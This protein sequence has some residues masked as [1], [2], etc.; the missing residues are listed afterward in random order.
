MARIRAEG[1]P[2]LP[3]YRAEQDGE[4][5][6]WAALRPHEAAGRFRAGRGA[7]LAALARLTPAEL[8]R[9]GVHARFGT[10][11]LALWVEFFL[12]HEAHHLY[13]ILR[14]VRGAD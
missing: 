4:W 11:P 14:R 5:P 2:A 7:L 3:Q 12:D 1:A 10:M 13:T 8:E 9:P 6:A